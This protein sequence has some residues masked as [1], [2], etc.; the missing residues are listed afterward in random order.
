MSCTPCTPPQDEFPIFCDPNPATDV[1]QRLLVED[2]A[3]CTKALVSPE[4][5]STLVWEDG[6]K[7]KQPP[8]PEPEDTFNETTPFLAEGTTEPRNLV[9]RFAD[10]VNVKDFGAVGDGVTD[11]T[12]AIQVAIDAFNLTRTTK[13]STLVF[14]SGK[15]KITSYLDFTFIGGE[16]G[17]IIGGDGTFEVATI[18]VDFD[19][20]T[21]DS[22]FKLGDSNS[23]SYQAGISISGFKFEKGSSSSYQPIGINAASLAQ[24]RISNI[25]VGSWNNTFLSL[26][27]PQNCRFE[28]ITLFS[29]GKSWLY[30]NSS[31]ITVTQSSTTVTASA[32]IFS[33]SD[34][35]H[36]IS[37]W[38]S[39]PNYQ[40]RKAKITT[41]ISPT[42]VIVDFDF[43]DTAPK[44][45]YFDAP[46]VSINSGSST[47]TADSSCFSPNDVGLIVYIKN[48]GLNGRLL[49]AKI[50]SYISATQVT[51]STNASNT[52]TN[53]EFTCPAVEIYTHSGASNGGSDNTFMNLQVENHRATGVV[54]H[55]Q[56]LLCF[57]NSK[58]HAE[59]TPDL[60][61]PAFS[62]SALWLDQV[63]GYFQGGTQAQYLDDSKI[64]AVYQT[65]LFN[66]ESISI[67]TAYNETVFEI[68]SK[69]PGFEGG[70]LNIGDLALAGAYSGK[71]IDELIVDNNTTSKG[72]F[73]AGTIS[74]DEY[75]QTRTYVGNEGTTGW[76]IVSPSA[77][78]WG[79]TD[80]SSPS[81]LE[82]KWQRIGYIVFY[83][84][85][86]E[87]DV[88]GSGN[89][90]ISIL[91]SS[92]M[93]IPYFG[94]EVDSGEYI[95]SCNGFIATGPSDFPPELSKAWVKYDS[96]NLMSFNVQ[97]NSGTINAKNACIN[98]FYFTK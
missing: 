97:L 63:S 78:T 83:E 32:S 6:I 21:T 70:L 54:M 75:N 38:G 11:D 12:A 23:P 7:W 80:P 89:N 61:I 42:Q 55:D 44:V 19:G 68:D 4:T 35:G 48:A 64:Y 66:F 90:A 59:Q 91:R 84:F 9:T 49:R 98:G 51:I 24:S 88:A 40:R 22:A 37:F 93:P 33:A 31:G 58:I 65:S 52:A 73:I 71:S 15:Y 79:G 82:Y 50:Q 87:Y 14:P 18:I 46:Y 92:D 72:Y 95:G 74:Y 56:D 25:T 26:A 47:L 3:F 69:A 2:E 1:G 10:V 57:V 8:P 86:L 5:G 17:E 41:Y 34:V 53:V 39:A 94:T 29:G 96:T 67:R 60:T 77:I 27:T 30:K 81:A 13:P 20:Y 36:T 28:N 43:T 85:R 62:Q 45:L 16:R 76:G